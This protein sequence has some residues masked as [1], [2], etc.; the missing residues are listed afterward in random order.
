MP[1]LPIVFP[2]SSSDIGGSHVATYELAVALQ[3]DFGRRCVFLCADGTP[4]ADEAR[5]LGIEVIDTGE[6]AWVHASLRKRRS[7]IA[8]LRRFP[9]RLA[10]MRQIGRCIVHANEIVAIQ[11]FGIIAK[12]LGGKIVYHHH[13]LNR[14]ALPNRFLINRADAVIA[15]SETCRAPLSFVPNERLQ[16]VLNPIDVPQVF[17]RHAARTRVCTKLK[18]DPGDTLVGFVG[19]LWD[20]KRPEF[21]LRV[22]S[23]MAATD[24]RM[25]FVIFGRKGD[26]DVPA[27]Q[28]LADTLGIADRVVF[29]GFMMPAEDNVAA[30]DL[31]MAP[32]IREPFGRTPIEAALLGTPWVATDDAGHGEIGRRWAGGRLVPIDADETAFAQ[33]ALTILANPTSVTATADQRLTIAADFSPHQ[34]AT[35]I[36]AIYRQLER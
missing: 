33:V 34:E 5:R 2:F 36:E 12:L 28:V 4:I 18:I 19:N 8:T 35:E 20:R 27:M 9:A 6:I 17:D 3:N 11:S 29:A 32:A 14:M 25:R 24:G 15:V 10:V 21:F 1:Q 23:V 16:V 26:V 30:L 31:L 22:A 13:A 7:P